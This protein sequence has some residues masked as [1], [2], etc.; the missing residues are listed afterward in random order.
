MNELVDEFKDKFH[1]GSN[2][3]G[4]HIPNDGTDNKTIE[5]GQTRFMDVL[6][7][8]MLEDPNSD[9]CQRQ[10]KQVDENI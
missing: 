2:G 8:T 9:Y 10:Q 6:K 5:N 1:S 3:T 7:A 4:K